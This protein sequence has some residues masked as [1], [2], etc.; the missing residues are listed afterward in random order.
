MK[1]TK[2]IYSLTQIWMQ[3]LYILI[4]VLIKD[5]FHNKEESVYIWLKN[6]NYF[7]FTN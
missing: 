2:D 7:K 1:F 6:F 4:I 5:I 3:E